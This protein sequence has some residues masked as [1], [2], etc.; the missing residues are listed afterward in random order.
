MNKLVRN[1]IPS[2]LALLFTAGCASVKVD[3][4]KI[5][6]VKRVAI[7]G[8][9]VQQQKSVSTMDLLK[10]AT[11]MDTKSKAE[12]S[13]RTE[14]DHISKMYDN[15]KKRLEQENGWKVMTQDALKKSPTYV[16]LFK[17]KTE[18]FKTVR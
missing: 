17:S 11:H 2:V 9:D 12:I 6:G 4:E 15:L 3:K 7:I 14:S 5:Q 10:V 18:G 8:F 1:I 16:S 13:G